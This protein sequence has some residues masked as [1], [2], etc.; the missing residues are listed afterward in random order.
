MAKKGV[1]RVT[2][3]MCRWGMQATDKTTGRFGFVHK[4]TAWMTN[5]P[6]FAEVLESWRS[7]VDEDGSVTYRHVHLMGGL[8]A[9][10]A[11]YPPALVKAI[12]GVMREH[13]E[14]GGALGPRGA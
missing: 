1:V 12:P 8:A 10:A 11:T 7:C 5:H 14:Q 3:P 9:P 2:G 6:G 13:L 4:Q